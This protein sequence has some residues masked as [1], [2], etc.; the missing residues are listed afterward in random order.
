MRTSAGKSP[1]CCCAGVVPQKACV[2]R[3][4]LPCAT[5]RSSLVHPSP[6][7]PPF[8]VRLTPSSPQF[9]VLTLRSL[10]EAF[11][12]LSEERNAATEDHIA[13]R[14]IVAFTRHQWERIDILVIPVDDHLINVFDT[15]Q[16]QSIA[17]FGVIGGTLSGQLLLNPRLAAAADSTWCQSCRRVDDLVPISVSSPSLKSKDGPFAG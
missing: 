16:K 4:K 11:E 6:F 13:G 12:A 1:A 8:R 14:A 2:F 9:V 3:S 10:R 15:W 5:S 7:W 17:D